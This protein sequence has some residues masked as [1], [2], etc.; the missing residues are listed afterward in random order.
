MTDYELF[1]L[2]CGKIVGNG[3]GPQLNLKDFTKVYGEA[4]MERNQEYVTDFLNEL[5]QRQNELEQDTHDPQIS[6]VEDISD[7]EHISDEPHTSDVEDN[8]DNTTE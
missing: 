8:N 1:R 2:S 7:V 6:D 4:K 3:P 5:H